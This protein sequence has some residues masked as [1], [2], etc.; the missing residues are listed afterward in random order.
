[1]AL[2]RGGWLVLSQWAFWAPLTGPRTL[3]GIDLS[4]WSTP[5]MIA[6]PL[7]FAPMWGWLSQSAATAVMYWCDRR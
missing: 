6:N 2:R 4:K 7:V 1:M 5:R 3:P